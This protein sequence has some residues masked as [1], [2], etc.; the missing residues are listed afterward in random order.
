M[1]TFSIAFTNNEQ[2]NKKIF[3]IHNK[4]KYNLWEV[5]QA[6]GLKRAN[7]IEMSETRRVHKFNHYVKLKEMWPDLLS[8]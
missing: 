4:N 6:E 2:L 7:T 1:V 5:L 3:L 8:V